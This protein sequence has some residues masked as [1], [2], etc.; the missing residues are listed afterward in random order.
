MADVKKLIAKIMSDMKN[1]GSKNFESKVYRDEPILRT[2]AQMSNFMPPEYREMRKIANQ[3]DTYRQSDGWLFYNQGKFME[4]FEDDYQYHGEF[5]RYFPTYQAMGDLQLRGYFSWRTKVRRG[6]VEET[7]LSFVF[8]YLYEL[9]NQIGVKTAEEGFRQLRHFWSVYKEIDPHINRYVRQW[10]SDYVVY[11][12]LDRSL[13]EEFTDLAFDRA[14]MI[15]MAPDSHSEEE[16]FLALNTLSS[17][18]LENSGFYKRYPED[19]RAVACGVFRQLSA[20]YEKNRKTSLCEKLFGKVVSA[21]YYMFS[22]A[23]FYDQKKYEEYEYVVSDLC[24]Y[25]CKNGVW[26]CR[27]LLGSRGKNQELGALLKNVDCLMR[28]R[29]EYK[30]LLKQ[31]KAT[32]T[33]LALI[34]KELDQW[35]ERRRR[36]EER[37]IEIDVSKLQGIRRAAETTRD[38]LIVEEEPEPAAPVAA[39]PADN[40]AGLE[41]TEYKFLLCLLRGEPYEGLLREKG[42]MLSVLVDSINEKLYDLIGD[43]AILFEG[44]RPEVLEDYMDEL[45]GILER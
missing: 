26:S 41:E 10:L 15:L 28:L 13:M 5:L 37:K 44:E 20:Y 27:K 31:E 21:P 29:Y 12:G 23:V 34:E 8:V 39:E 2:A 18:N 16:L 3:Y 1:Q 38:K 9:L 45:K 40:E 43:T 35:L 17:Y 19:M 25:S 33:L 11:Y 14:L 36:A 24:G 32:K 6:Q 42:V 22:S 30:P 7:S 4:A